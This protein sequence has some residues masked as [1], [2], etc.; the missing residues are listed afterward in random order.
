MTLGGEA[1]AEILTAGDVE[2]LGLIPYS[3]NYTFLTRVTSG[4]SV[5][6]AIYKP[7]KGER[8][9]W[10]FPEG[11][12]ASREV[13]AYE[14]SAAVGWDIVPPTVVRSDAPLG[15][16][17][18]QLFIEHDPNR[19]YLVL[20]EKRRDDLRLFA[21]FDVVAN[22]ADR[23]SG[24]VLEDT[25]GRLWAIDHGVT[26]H[27]EPK[28]RTVIWEYAEEEVP[29]SLLKDLETLNEKL[30]EGEPFGRRLGEL[31]SEPEVEATRERVSGLLRFGCF[32]AP[33]SERSLPWPLI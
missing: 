22:N 26:F 17:S 10:D 21:A 15:E 30:E 7:T 33:V 12:L 28:L 8:P 1:A 29:A 19:H 9:L 32:P 25:G 31:L 3:S 11:T 4:E 2:V 14:L 5:V 6:N 24:H 13:A 18:L 23:K 16:G 20:K 27:P